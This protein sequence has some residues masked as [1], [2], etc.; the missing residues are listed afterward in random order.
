MVR[1][2]PGDYF[3]GLGWNS[4]SLANGS[5]ENQYVMWRDVKNQVFAAEPHDSGCADNVNQRL[6]SRIAD[7]MWPY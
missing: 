3:D 6:H 7:K 5:V 1:P 4:L 2:D